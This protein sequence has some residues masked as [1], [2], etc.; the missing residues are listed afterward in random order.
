[1]L[2]CLKPLMYGG[3]ADTPQEVLKPATHPSG[4]SASPAYISSMRSNVCLFYVCS[5]QNAT[6]S[7]KA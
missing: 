1:M 3:H 5:Q 2:L 7:A 6:R 4:M